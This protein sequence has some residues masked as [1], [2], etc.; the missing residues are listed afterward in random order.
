M[1]AERRTPVSEVQ[2]EQP[3]LLFSDEEEK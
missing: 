1:V 2:E 3:K